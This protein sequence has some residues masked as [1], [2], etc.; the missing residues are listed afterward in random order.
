M[1]L[2]EGG[3]GGGLGLVYLVV[4]K[5]EGRSSLGLLSWGVGETEGAGRGAG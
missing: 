5:E 4:I 3:E 2:G 1:V